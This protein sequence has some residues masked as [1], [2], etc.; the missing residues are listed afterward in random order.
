MLTGAAEEVGLGG[1][2]GR[3]HHRRKL[4]KFNLDVGNGWCCFRHSSILSLKWRFFFF[5]F[6]WVNNLMEI[7]WFCDERLS[8]GVRGIYKFFV[9]NC[10]F[11]LAASKFKL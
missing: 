1:A 6:L 4:D 9:A 8:V 3:R 2:A 11:V 5:F 7:T 10:S